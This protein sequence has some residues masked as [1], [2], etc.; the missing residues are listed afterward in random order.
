MTKITCFVILNLNGGPSNTPI[1]LSSHPVTI[2]NGL[3]GR[4]SQELIDFDCPDI[5]PTEVPVSAMNTC[6]N[7][8]T[9]T[10]M[11]HLDS[12]PSLVLCILYICVWNRIKARNMY[13]Y[14]SLKGT[15]FMCICWLILMLI[16]FSQITN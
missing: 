1:V 16:Y 4:K 8:E 15:V 5:S 12:I 7:L 10:I 2:R 6:P 14:Y 3:D 13:F 11:L 9:K